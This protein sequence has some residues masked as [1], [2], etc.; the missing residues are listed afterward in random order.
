MSQLRTSSV[1]HK[2]A[3]ND[4]IK[5]K[6][7]GSSIA[8]RETVAGDESLT[9]ATKGYVD[10]NGGGGGDGAN[11]SVGE[12]PPSGATEGDLW[13]DSSDGG[14]SNGGRMYVYYSG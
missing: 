2:D 3:S 7:D 6:V 14:G 13:W 12:A 8:G 11:V 10:A 5:L 1:S 9:L 4:N